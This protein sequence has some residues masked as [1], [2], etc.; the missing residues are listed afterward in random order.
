MGIKDWQ[1]V[2]FAVEGDHTL[3]THNSADFRGKGGGVQGGHY[4]ALAIH[5]GLVCLNSECA[6]TPSRQKN[7]FQHVLVQ[8]DGRPDLVN[9]AFEVFEGAEGEITID[10]YDIPKAL[11]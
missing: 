5:A 11:H 1:L 4:A 10:L 9:V 6:M 2:E 3:V 8:L 7:L